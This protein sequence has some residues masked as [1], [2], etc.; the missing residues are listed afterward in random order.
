MLSP[1]TPV[2]NA[3][4]CYILLIC[5]L[6][7]FKPSFLY[8]NEKK[9][10]KSFGFDEDK[11]IMPFPMVAIGSGILLYALFIWIQIVFKYLE[12]IDN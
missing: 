2:Y 7:I 4:I 10:F 8:S 11:T 9:R 12:K 6:L 3:I 5:I 1:D